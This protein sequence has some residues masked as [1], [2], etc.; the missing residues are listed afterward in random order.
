LG[1]VPYSPVA[2]GVLTGKYPPDTPPP[3]DSRAGRKDPRM[4][5]SEWRPESLAIAQTLKRHAEARGITAGQFALAWVLN[6]SFVSS[7]IAGPRTEAQWTEYLGAL[8]YRFT[9]EDEAL[10]DS[11]VPTGHPSTPGYNDPA[12]PI[13]GRRPLS[14]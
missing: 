8:G 3:A 14:G 5:Q 13:E 2:R 6:N 9:P 12:Y 10:V 7:A 4:L 11:L 1:V